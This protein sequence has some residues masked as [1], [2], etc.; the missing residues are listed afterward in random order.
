[1]FFC[2]VFIMTSPKTFCRHFSTIKNVY[3]TFTGLWYVK[4]CMAVKLWKFDPQYSCEVLTW[5]V[6]VRSV[7]L[8]VSY[9]IGKNILDN[10]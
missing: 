6:V 8:G 4:F 3:V 9:N 1:M 7:H 5:V 2:E 10:Q